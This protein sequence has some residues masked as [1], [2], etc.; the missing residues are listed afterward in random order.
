MSDETKDEAPKDEVLDLE[1]ED[2]VEDGD[3]EKKAEDEKKPGLKDKLAA[4]K[5]L[6]IAVSFLVIIAG[7]VAG[8]YF[9]GML[10]AKKPH[11]ISMALPGESVYHEIPKITVD[12]KPSPQH[13]RPFI[14]LVMQVQLQDE[15]AKTAFVERQTKILDAIQSHLR[16]LTVQ[17]LEGEYG[18][19]LLRTNLVLVINNIIKPEL[20]MTVLYKEFMIR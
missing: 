8:L 14:R 7:A 10:T 18:T 16:S 5:V 2:E 12:L 1:V 9:T 6:V 3:G 4:N 13:A 17:E 15:T 20:A 19:E 11:Q